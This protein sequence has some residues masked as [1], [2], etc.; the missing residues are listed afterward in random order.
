DS[1]LG[2]LTARSVTLELA[3]ALLRRLFDQQVFRL[4]KQTIPAGNSFECGVRVHR[5]EPEINHFIAITREQWYGYVNQQRLVENLPASTPST[6]GKVVPHPDGPERPRH[7]WCNG[8]CTSINSGRAFELLKFM[9]D[10]RS[11]AFE[12]L[13]GP[14]AAWDDN[15]SD[16]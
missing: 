10:K 15:L 11:S 13:S 16:E 6:N 5:V 12:E 7:F 2:T 14:G 3:I 4:K 1:V 8:K 9:W